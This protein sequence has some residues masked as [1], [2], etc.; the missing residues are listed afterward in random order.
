MNK[1]KKAFTLLEILIVLTLISIFVVV[2][3]RSFRVDDLYKKTDKLV[4]YKVLNIV[5]EASKKL[6]NT[7]GNCPSGKFMEQVVGSW[8]LTTYKGGSVISTSTDIYDIFKKYIKFRNGGVEFCNHT[9]YCSTTGIVGGYLSGNILIGFQ[10]MSSISDCPS[11]YQP[12]STNKVALEEFD[13]TKTKCW[14]KLYID[15]NGN[16]G[17]NTEGNDVFI[18]GLKDSGVAR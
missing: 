8:D 5:E 18:Y 2:F 16:K 1:K 13:G 11:A 3:T 17:P 6:L 10:K 12:T 7:P 9:P 4:Q 15:T 14:A